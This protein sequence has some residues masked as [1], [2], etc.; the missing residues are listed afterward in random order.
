MAALPAASR[1]MPGVLSLS[2]AEV[3][4]LGDGDV[5]V[6]DGFL[7]AAGALVAAAA[8]REL[9]AAGALTPAMIGRE[10]RHRP[11]VRGDRT[12]WFAELELPVGLRPLFPAFEALRLL[13]NAE[14]WLGLQRFELQLACYAGDGARYAP[15]TDTFAGGAG[16]RV[17]AIVY[18]NPGWSQADEGLLVAQTPRGPVRIEPILDR[19]V[20]FL[21]DRVVHEVEPTWAPRLAATAWF[22]G[23]EAIPLLPDVPSTHP[24]TQARVPR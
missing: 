16:R 23:A 22:R 19:L 18:L 17:T 14:A 6:R 11:D 24:A 5:V 7:G 10:R 4:R 21:S 2:A 12:A 8:L 15:H 20:L 3:H 9:D 13:L 1:D